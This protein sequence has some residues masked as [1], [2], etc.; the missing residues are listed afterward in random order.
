MPICWYRKDSRWRHGCCA[1]PPPSVCA[2]HSFAASIGNISRG[3]NNMPP[4]SGPKWRDIVLVIEEFVTMTLAGEFIN[5]LAF[6]VHYRL[7]LV[8]G[9]LLL[10]FLARGFLGC[11][12]YQ[13][14]YF[15]FHQCVG[16]YIASVHCLVHASVAYIVGIGKVVTKGV[17]EKCSSG[18]AT[19]PSL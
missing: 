5:F 2:G 10:Y 7:P 17:V 13:W 1:C 15:F 18:S 8:D 16:Y 19:T 11:D 12:K 4:G 14:M 6:Q 3:Y 9:S